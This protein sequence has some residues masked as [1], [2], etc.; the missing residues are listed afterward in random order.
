MERRGCVCS[1]RRQIESGWRLMKSAP[2]GAGAPPTEPALTSSTSS[3]RSLMSTGIAPSAAIAWW[4]VASSSTVT[5]TTTLL[6][7]ALRSYSSCA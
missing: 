4:I 3:D 2:L 5:L 7:D 1:R 6:A